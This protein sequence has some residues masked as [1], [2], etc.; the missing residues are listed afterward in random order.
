MALPQVAAGGDGL[1]VWKK[2]AVN[3]VKKQSWPLR[4]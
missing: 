4:E 3:I 2:V 1:Q